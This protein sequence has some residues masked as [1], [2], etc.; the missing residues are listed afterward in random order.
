MAT[1]GGECGGSVHLPSRLGGLR[2]RR[3]SS[4]PAGSGTE[5]KPKKV[6]MHFKRRVTP[7]AEEILF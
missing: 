6:L 5:P 3:K 4:R 2:E 7:V 1:K